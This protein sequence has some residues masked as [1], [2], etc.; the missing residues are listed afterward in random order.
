MCPF[1]SQKCTHGHSQ[2]QKNLRGVICSRTPK[3]QGA[4]P[5]PA[6]IS[7]SRPPAVCSRCATDS[8]T[9]QN[10]PTLPPPKK[11]VL[12]WTGKIFRP[13][14]KIL[15]PPLAVVYGEKC[16]I[17]GC[18]KKNLLS[19]PSPRTSAFGQTTFASTGESS[20]TPI[21]RLT[22]FAN[23]CIMPRSLTYWR[24]EHDFG[25]VAPCTELKWN[26]YY[27]V[28]ERKLKRHV[29]GTF[30]LSIRS[31]TSTWVKKRK[32]ILLVK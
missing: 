4:I 2:N 3:R 10:P 13:L 11:F 24:G 1:S 25:F 28:G 22:K 6:P 14:F 16:T 12:T 31:K 15:D 9:T 30:L 26:I 19:T 8:T 20:P 27:I 5:T 18:P 23:L 32:L 17:F 21:I 7:P 29:I